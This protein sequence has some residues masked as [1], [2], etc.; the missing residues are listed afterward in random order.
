MTIRS[1]EQK[2]S[3][4]GLKVSICFENGEFRSYATVVSKL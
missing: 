2:Y 4:S 1:N 3:A